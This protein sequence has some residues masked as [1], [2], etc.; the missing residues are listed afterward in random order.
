M[1][2][3]LSDLQ[4]AIFNTIMRITIIG[5]GLYQMVTSDWARKAYARELAAGNFNATP[6]VAAPSI[7]FPPGEGCR[8]HSRLA[9]AV[10]KPRAL[11]RCHL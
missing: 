10:H 11:A 8:C 3:A 7:A 2:E 5:I 6:P 1:Q 4:L 9:H